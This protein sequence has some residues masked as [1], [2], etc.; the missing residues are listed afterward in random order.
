[1][2][3]C[4]RSDVN[5]RCAVSVVPVSWPEA[6]RVNRRVRESRGISLLGAVRGMPAD[7]TAIKSLARMIWQGPQAAEVRAMDRDFSHNL[8]LFS[9][10]GC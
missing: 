6:G 10:L 7:S 2:V 8:H 3:L 1:M 4:A 9:L 5:G